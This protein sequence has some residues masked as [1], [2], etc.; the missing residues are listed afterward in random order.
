M[1]ANKY[2][3]LIEYMR[4][5]FLPGML[6]SIVVGGGMGVFAYYGSKYFVLFENETQYEMI[7]FLFILLGGGV[8]FFIMFSDI[9][10]IVATIKSESNQTK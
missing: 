2:A 8:A 7:I 5:V 3:P 1:S 9:L 6:M 4:K 10:R